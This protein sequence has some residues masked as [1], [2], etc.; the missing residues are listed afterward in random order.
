M[1]GNKLLHV[2]KVDLHDMTYQ[3]GRDA[4]RSPHD[5]LQGVTGMLPEK[6]TATVDEVSVRTHDE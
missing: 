6:G 1:D 3:I 5:T 4:S 2:F